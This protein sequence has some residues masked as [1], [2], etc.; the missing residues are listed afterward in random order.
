MAMIKHKILDRRDA[1]NIP[2]KDL[3]IMIGVS[4]SPRLNSLFSKSMDSFPWY[5]Y[6]QL[7]E[8]LAREG[9]DDFFLLDGIG[10]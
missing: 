2:I 10:L 5:K 3:K 8:V 9:E 6:F 4:A 1:L 7:E